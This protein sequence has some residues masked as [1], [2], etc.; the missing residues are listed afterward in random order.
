MF[1]MLATHNKY[2]AEVSVPPLTWSN[3]LARSAMAYAK[4]LKAES[5]YLNK[6]PMRHSDQQLR[7]GSGE[8][9]AWR[10]V[11][12]T[13]SDIWGRTLLASPSTIAKDWGDEKYHYDYQSN[14]CRRGEQ[15]GHYTQMIW[16]STRKVG[17]ARVEQ[18][19]RDKGVYTARKEELWVC[20]YHPAG[21]WRGRRPY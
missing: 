21:N 19:F 20:H 16:E 12:S 11:R 13:S 18:N 3:E 9:L 6:I 17:C 15:C 10:L 5:D 1:G 7:P 8:N 14:S 2:R 4:M